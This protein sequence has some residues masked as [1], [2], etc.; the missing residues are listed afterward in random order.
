MDS[1][2]YSQ[3][4]I[5]SVYVPLVGHICQGTGAG[6]ES[7]LAQWTLDMPPHSM[8]SL[9]NIQSCILYVYV[10]LIGQSCQGTGVGRESRLAQWTLDMPPH[11]M[12]SLANIQSCIF[13]MFMFPL[14]DT[15]AKYLRLL[16][17]LI[18]HNKCQLTS[19][20]KYAPQPLLDIGVLPHI[21]RAVCHRAALLIDTHTML[22][23]VSFNPPPL[24]FLTK[25]EWN[26]NSQAQEWPIWCWVKNTSW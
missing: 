11:R 18:Y 22:Y 23:F 8:D 24:F 17:I 21:R 15:A 10:P 3:P 25:Q 7:R 26:G 20:L 16:T 19:K 2:A 5:L 4:C 1:M 14:L 6:R 9:A 13:Y 12:D